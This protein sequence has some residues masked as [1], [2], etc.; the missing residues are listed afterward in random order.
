MDELHLRPARPADHATFARL[1]VELATGDA[2]PDPGRFEAQL[3]GD[4]TIAEEGGRPVGYA[5]AQTLETTGYVR[6]LVVDPA[7]RRRGVG[8]RI[9]VALA[10]RFRGAGCRRWCLNVKPDNH[11]ARAL[12][13]SCGMER[14]RATEVVRLAWGDEERLPVAAGLVAA[15]P[16]EDD[17]AFEDRFGVPRGLLAASRGAGKIALGA[18]ADGGDPAGLACFDPLFPGSFPF[19][20]VDGSVARALVERCR[21]LRAAIVD[22]EHRWREH[23]HQVVIEGDAALAAAL[24]AVGGVRVLETLHYAGDLDRAPVG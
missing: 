10:A 17:G 1:F 24:I 12:Y 13:E 3:M 19:A 15:V 2:V 6:H 11:A 5:Y 14:G 4:T 22:P 18:R 23:G 16:P 20:A 21:E 8:R 9:L 7:A